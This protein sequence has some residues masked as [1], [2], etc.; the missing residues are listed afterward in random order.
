MSSE[1][2]CVVCGLP[3]SECKAQYGYPPR[4]LTY[5][6]RFRALDELDHRDQRLIERN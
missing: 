4:W 6:S 5:A 1:K 3:R 2:R